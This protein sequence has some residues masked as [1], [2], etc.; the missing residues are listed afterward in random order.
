M[1]GSLHIFKVFMLY[2]PD[3]V[4]FVMILNGIDQWE[5]DWLHSHYPRFPEITLKTTLRHGH[6]LDLLIDNFKKTIWYDR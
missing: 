2:A 6:L 4:N 3:T 1:P 5:E